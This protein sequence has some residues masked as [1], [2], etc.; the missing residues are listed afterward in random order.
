MP[1][2]ITLPS[3]NPYFIR[4]LVHDWQL[5]LS[6]EL[7]KKKKPKEKLMFLLII[8]MIIQN[9]LSNLRNLCIIEKILAEVNGRKT[10]VDSS[11]LLNKDLQDEFKIACEGLLNF[12]ET[13][14][15]TIL[16]MTQF[17]LK[18]KRNTE[19]DDTNLIKQY[20]LYCKMNTDKKPT[21]ENLVKHTKGKITKSRWSR[22]LG[23]PEVYLKLLNE[24]EKKRKYAKTEEKRDFWLKVHTNYSDF[25]CDK[26]LRSYHQKH[27]T[28]TEKHL[29]NTNIIG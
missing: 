13:V 3:E 1:L 12:I 26:V 2:N 20:I 18:E 4:N 22:K 11:L 28:L 5:L 29:D 19:T 24:I 27:V 15:Q 7:R 10:Y 14:I 6:N 25:Y 9:K 17:D 21:L 23:S 8:K 16:I